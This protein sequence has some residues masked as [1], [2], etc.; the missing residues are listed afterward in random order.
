MECRYKIKNKREK[1][2]Q[3][4]ETMTKVSLPDLYLFSQSLLFFRL[5]VGETKL[6]LTN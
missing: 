2:V 5:P 1:S 3:R 4:L 6:W